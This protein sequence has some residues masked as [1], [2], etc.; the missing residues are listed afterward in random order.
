MTNMIGTKHQSAGLERQCRHGVSSQRQPGCQDAAAR[1]LAS[2]GAAGQ[3]Y[4]EWQRHALPLVFAASGMWA[5]EAYTPEAVGRCHAKPPQKKELLAPGSKIPQ[6]G[7][8][9]VAKAAPSLWSQSVAGSS[10]A[11]PSSG[12]SV[13]S[14]AEAP[15]QSQSTAASLHRERELAC[16]THNRKPRTALEAPS[17]SSDAASLSSGSVAGLG[18]RIRASL[19]GL[20]AVFVRSPSKRKFGKQRPSHL[21]ALSAALPEVST[22]PAAKKL[23]PASTPPRPEKPRA[24][25]RPAQE[26]AKEPPAAK[27]RPIKPRHRKVGKQRPS[28]LAPVGDIMRLPRPLGATGPDP[29]ANDAPRVKVERV[30]AADRRKA[31]GPETKQATTEVEPKELPK[32]RV[33]DQAFGPF[34]RAC[35]FV[36]LSCHFWNASSVTMLYGPRYPIG[37]S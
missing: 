2:M 4:L 17:Q 32:A 30:S 7:N 23:P 37:G 20:S 10:I 19:S 16:Q 24:S 5:F 27:A 36:C 6:V 1:H 8:S 28:Y 18:Q 3:G 35:V 25:K 26:P 11:V 34:C 29:E 9:E 22:P 31:S 33:K 21:P 12:P 15:I 13:A 14:T